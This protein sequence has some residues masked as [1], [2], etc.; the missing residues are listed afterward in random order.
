MRRMGAPRSRDRITASESQSDQRIRYGGRWVSVA[1][2]LPLN[3]NAIHPWLMA[4]LVAAALRRPRGLAALIG[5]L[6][7]TPTEYVELSRTSAGQAL[8]EYFGQRAM[9]VVP[10]T[11]FCRGVLLLPTDHAAYLRGR[12]RQ[13]VRTNLRRAAAAGIECEV[14]N[15]PRRAVDDI[16]HVSRRHWSSLSE[17]EFHAAVDLTRATVKRPEMTV[18][19]ARDEHGR[20]LAFATT[21]IDDVVCLV[22]AAV[23]TS[24]EARWALHDH[25]VRVLIDRRVRY[26]LVD[27]GGPFGAL[28]FERNLQH[29][30]HLLGYEL[31]HVIPVRAHSAPRRKRL[32]AS[33]VVA[34]ATV[35]AIVPRAVADTVVPAPVKRTTSHH[36]V[37]SAPARFVSRASANP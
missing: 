8:D 3:E 22:N 19:V 30:Q 16:C 6:L 9:W 13:A 4:R 35:A 2:A 31:R 5:V 21:V 36:A 27:G 1:S 37:Q 17:A 34:A 33:F 18:T 7:R 26:L 24:H 11:R 15:D 28:G 32:V 10:R 23:A 25:L 12:H 29:Y 14:V 20:P